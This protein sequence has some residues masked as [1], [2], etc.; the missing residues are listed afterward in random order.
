MYD[1]DGMTYAQ[2]R[3]R[4]FEPVTVAFTFWVSAFVLLASGILGLAIS[5]V[6]RGQRI[7][8]VKL[9][10]VL[11]M[12]CAL[13]ILVS[14]AQQGQIGTISWGVIIGSGPLVLLALLLGWERWIATDD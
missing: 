2:A 13:I 1:A 12:L 9:V 3:E 7:L 10:L 11:P 4:W 8:I 5:M 14:G 6:D